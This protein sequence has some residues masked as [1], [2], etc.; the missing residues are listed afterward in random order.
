MPGASGAASQPWGTSPGPGVSVSSRKPWGRASWAPRTL[1]Q[2][3]LFALPILSEPGKEPEA[4]E[5]EELV[6]RLALALMFH[7]FIT[8]SFLPTVVTPFPELLGW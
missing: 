8:I 1:T 3:F 4:A 5:E 6:I 2:L 7:L